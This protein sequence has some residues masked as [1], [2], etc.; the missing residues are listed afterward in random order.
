MTG[1]P[2]IDRLARGGLSNS[3]LKCFTGGASNDKNAKNPPRDCRWLST[4]ATKPS[5]TT[6]W[7][8]LDWWLGHGGARSA[9]LPDDRLAVC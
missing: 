8:C 7:I 3:S 1:A 4:W 6:T 9:A 2:L 5:R